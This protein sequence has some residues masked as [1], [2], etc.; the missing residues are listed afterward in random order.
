MG[1][2]MIKN[3]LSQLTCLY[4][5]FLVMGVSVTCFFEGSYDLL[6]LGSDVFAAGDGCEERYLGSTARWPAAGW[7]DGMVEFSRQRDRY[8]RGKVRGCSRREGEWRKQ[9]I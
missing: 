5:F 6:R 7:F 4:Q 8:S 2:P 1:M 9:E 3:T